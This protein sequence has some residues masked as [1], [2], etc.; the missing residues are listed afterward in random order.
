MVISLSSYRKG[1]NIHS[2]ETQKEDYCIIA[3]VP[4]Q[5]ETS[6]II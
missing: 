3:S 1:I 5:Q 6:Q 4:K 2:S